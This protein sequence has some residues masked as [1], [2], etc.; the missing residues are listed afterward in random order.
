MKVHLLQRLVSINHLTNIVTESASLS[1]PPSEKPISQNKVHT[2][3][4]VR[5]RVCSHAKGP[6]KDD[7]VSI[8]VTITY[9]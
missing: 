2:Q 1:P 9:I 4:I 8:N 5:L 6:E 3:A 7:K